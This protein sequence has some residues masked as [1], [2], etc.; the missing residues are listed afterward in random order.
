MQNL[1]SRRCLLATLALFG[2]LCAA[3]SSHADERLAIDLTSGPIIGAAVDGLESWQGIPYAEPPVADL[4]WQPPQPVK[5]WTAPIKANALASRCAQN[6]DLGVFAKAGG[7]EDCLYLNVYRDTN[8]SNDRQ[9]LPVFVWLHGGA[10]QVGQGGDYDPSKLAR[11]GKAVVVTLNYR[12]G[13]FGFLAHPALDSEGHDFGNYGLMDQQA[14]LQWVQ[15]NI[16]AFGGDPSNVTIAGESS[17]GNSVMVHMASPQSA[18]L[19][20]HAIA[21]SGGG[22]MTRHPAFGAPRPLAVAQEVG[23]AF[24]KEAGC[25][26]GEANCLRALPTKRILDIQAPFA[27][28]EFI[29]DGKSLPMHPSDAYRTGKINHAT[30]VN[31]STRD[32]GRFFVALPELMT[33]KVMKEVDYPVE[34]ERMYGKALAPKVLREYPFENYDSPSEAFAAAATDSMFAC[35]GLQ[36]SRVLADKIP[37]YAYEFGD[38]TAPSYVGPTSFPMLAAHTYELPYL[39]PGF[40]GGGDMQVKLNLLQEKLSDQM[41]AH[42]SNVAAVA[43]KQSDWPR[44]DPRQD[45]VMTFALPTAKVVSGR[46]AD[47][48]H[49]EFWDQ[50]G[51]Y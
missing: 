18:G 16:A 42:F 7:S 9:K 20:Q 2:G 40:R 31:G 19:F 44:F 26:T 30:L 50:T 5:H 13:V 11:Q 6:A 12:L 38:R 47:T 45:N 15:R 34:I 25:D 35:T 46:F 36:M 37:V 3:L 14:A 28:N 39:F 4:R 8:A 33:G 48:H 17:G 32:E 29:V 23:A 49:C 10:L 41:V 24:A 51:V 27:L 43:G 22:V 1:I 21:M